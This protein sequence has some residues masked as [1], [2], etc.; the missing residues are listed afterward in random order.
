VDDAALQRVAGRDDEILRHV[1]WDV[2][3]LEGREVVLE[4]YDDSSERWGHVLADTLCQFRRPAEGPAHGV[5][6]VQPRPTTRPAASQPAKAGEGTVL[7]KE[8]PLR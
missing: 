1:I 2:R 5:T 8:P 7:S 3:A 6:V 4:I